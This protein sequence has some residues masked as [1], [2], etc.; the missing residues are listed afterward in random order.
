MIGARI[1][2]VLCLIG[3][4]ILGAGFAVWLS[5]GSLR[6]PRWLQTAIGIVHIPTVFFGLAIFLLNLLIVRLL[7]YRVRQRDTARQSRLFQ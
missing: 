3:L 7:V 2:A 6:W 4:A 1:F 5:S